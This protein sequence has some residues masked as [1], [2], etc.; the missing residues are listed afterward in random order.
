LESFRECVADAVGPELAEKIFGAFQ[1]AEADEQL[2][3]AIAAQHVVVVV[4]VGTA[5]APARRSRYEA[6]IAFGAERDMSARGSGRTSSLGTSAH[7]PLCRS[8]VNT[9]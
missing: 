4:V 6:V 3:R 7:A 1:R 9:I 5:P 8:I 2:L